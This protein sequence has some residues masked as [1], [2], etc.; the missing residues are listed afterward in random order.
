MT[1]CQAPLVV[2]INDDNTIE[3]NETFTVNLAAT[4]PG[5]CIKVSS[6]TVTIID[7]ESKFA[8]TYLNIVK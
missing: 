8:I 5:V 2:I 6:V 1:D 7:D 4:H 3:E